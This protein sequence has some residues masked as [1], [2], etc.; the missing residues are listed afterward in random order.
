M[1][2]FLKYFILILGKTFQS[3]SIEEFSKQIPNTTNV[4]YACTGIVC[5]T[6]IEYVVCPSCHSVYEYRDCIE[7]VHGEKQSKIC[8]H[9]FFPKHPHLSRRKP[10]GTT[11]LKKVKSGRGCRLV[12]VKTFPYMPLKSSLQSLASR[13]GFITACEQWRARVTTSSNHTYLR[14][15]YD[16][17]VWHDFHSFL[18]QPFSY[19]LTLNVDWFQPFLHTQY[20]VG[21][22]YLIQCRIC[23]VMFDVKKKMSF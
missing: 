9:I 13:P 23:L 4:A 3:H 18:S 19:L 11:L 6:F 7:I 20:S 12:P 15:I 2:K 16:G 14:D 22:I 21:G 8:S 17:K 5:N 1:L 10:C